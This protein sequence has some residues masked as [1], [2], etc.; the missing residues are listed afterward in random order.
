MKRFA[1]MLL[2]LC[3]AHSFAADQPCLILAAAPPPTGVATWSQAGRQ[4]R[5]AL[6]YLAG[7]F[8]PGIP[9]RSQIKDKDVEKIKAKG[10]QVIVLD[11]QYTRGD[12]DAAKKQC[13]TAIQ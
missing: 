11:S 10:A 4:Q 1:I 2:A 12:L 3:T 5:H 13:S 7:S 8:P 6:I 9:F